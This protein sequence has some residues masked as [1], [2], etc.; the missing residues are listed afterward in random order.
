[1]KR[2]GRRIATVALRRTSTGVRAAGALRDH[3]GWADIGPV[4]SRM[5]QAARSTAKF[6]AF[7]GIGMRLASLPVAAL[8]IWVSYGTAF[9]LVP[10]AGAGSAAFFA[11]PISLLAL[12]LIADN[13]A[14]WG[15]RLS[16]SVVIVSGAFTLTVFA[17][18]I[19]LVQGARPW[20][21]FL[22]P[23]GDAVGS[24]ASDVVTGLAAGFTGA[25]VYVLVGYVFGLVVAGSSFYFKRPYVLDFSLVR[26]SEVI[27]WLTSDA[28]RFRDIGERARMCNKIEQVARIL[29]RG[30]PSLLRTGRADVDAPV[31]RRLREAALHVRG[32][33]VWMA[34]PNSGSQRELLAACL[35]LY[36]ALAVA[37]FDAL[38]AGPLP[39]VPRARRLGAVLRGLR[40]VVVASLPLV[41][42]IV[43]RRFDVK[44]SEPLNSGALAVS[45]LLAVAGL[46]NVLDASW[47][48][49]LAAVK[50]VLEPFKAFG[51]GSK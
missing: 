35:R 38:P 28:A 8:G 25:L 30:L 23:Q 29:D 22:Q 5:R 51:G 50:D 34:L 16:S 39:N 46:M 33:Q 7:Q 24:V 31:R 14:R 10:N 47:S 1:V 19:G 9:S 6:D 45:A 4:Q 27:I 42:V 40:T 13:R 18:L 21:Y 49:R 15:V 36:G 17:W 11:L 32:Y 44:L 37:E 48:S 3:A 26:L 41:A 2:L 20:R 12:L 43:L